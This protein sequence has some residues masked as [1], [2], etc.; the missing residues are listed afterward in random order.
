[1][2]SKQRKRRRK[3][4]AAQKAPQRPPISAQAE[5]EKAR[6]RGRRSAKGWRA[7]L[8][9]IGFL[10]ALWTALAVSL[11]PSVLRGVVESRLSEAVNAPV[12]IESLSV[13]PFT[14]GIAVRGIRVPYL[15]E[16]GTPDGALLTIERLDIRPRLRLFADAAPIQA[17]LSVHNPVLDITYLGN[18]LFSFSKLLP[19]PDGADAGPDAPLFAVSDLDLEG[20][21]ILLRDGPV[22]MLHTVSDVSFHVPLL[23]SADLP[24][25]PTLSALVNGTRINVEGR[26]EPDAGTLRTTFAIHTA[27]LHMEHFKRYL[28]DFTPLTLNSGTVALDMRFT[29]SQP[30]LGKVESS[31]SGTVKIEDAE[32]A[33]PEGAI[34]G[35]LRKGQASLNDFTLSER[36]IRLDGMELDGLYLRVSRDK[37]GR[38]DWADWLG[39]TDAN[40]ENLSPETPFVV[41][42]ADLILRNSDFTW[43]DASLADTQQIE[44]TGVDGRIAE[45]ST[46]P[47]AR[48]AMRLSFGISTEGV[49]A[50][51][52][53]GTLNPPSLNASLWVDDLP[54]MVL[55]PLLGETPLNDILGRIAIKGGVRFG[56]DGKAP[57]APGSGTSLAVTDA[58]ASV[59]ALSFGRGS[60]LSAADRKAGKDAGSPAVR[61]RALTFNGLHFDTQARSASV[62]ALSVEAP[63]VRV[64]SSGGIGLAVPGTKKPAGKTA[65]AA[66]TRLPEGMF[67]AALPDAAKTFLSDWKLKADGFRIAGGKLEHVAA[68]KA[69]KL[70]SSLDLETGPLSGDLTNTISL[71]L[72]ARGA[73]SGSL[74]LKGTLRPVPLRFSAGMD[75]ADLPLEWFDTPLRASTNLSPSGRLS[76]NLDAAITEEKGKGLD[77]LASGSLTVRDLRLKDARTEKVYALLRRL[78][79]DTFRFSSASSSFEAKAV[80]L[81]LLRMDVA[82]NAD[83]T[84]DI[85]DCIPKQ[86]APKPSSFRFSVASLKLQD[87][88]LLFRDQAHGSVSA[89]QDINA[90]VNG[91]SS[92]GGLPDIVLTGQLGGA[93]ITLSGSCNPFSTPPAAKL[94]FTAKG[95]DLAR[96][97]AYTRAYLGHP[98]VQGRLDLESAFTTS[99]WT[100]SLDNHIRL[101]KPVLGPKDTRPGAPDYPVSLGFALL[102][103]L[104]GN[105]ALDLPISGRLDDAALQVGGL[106]GKALGGLFT[107]VV[108][109]PFALLGGII[110]LVTPDDPALQVIAFPPGDTRINPA[111]QERLKRI[112]KALEEHPRV[113]IELVGMYEPASDT[114]G[115][116]RLRVIRKVQARHH[117]ALPAKQRAANPAGTIKL[118]PGEYERF[119]LHVYKDSPAGRKAAGGEEPDIMEQKLQALENVTQADLEALAHSRAEEVRAFLLKHGPGLGKRVGIASKGGLPD[120]RRGT[121]QVEIQLR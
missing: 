92:S 49:L 96:Y 5:E 102:E 66:K 84:L 116:K 46:R 20:G 63:E 38:I 72:R 8:V 119:L 6:S 98:V 67:T 111:A 87:A 12:T 3:R 112:A 26:T 24:F 14:L 28:S 2:A 71:T 60:S 16:V 34:V 56:P 76:A 58:E 42:G 89:V 93:P 107:K 99:G 10:C 79:A 18:G 11:P 25:A 32:I 97:S 43:V 80:L 53:E 30:H 15:E 40:P 17:A 36:R 4:R 64:A 23:H 113:K 69:E 39:G 48:T 101:E 110:G 22:G 83:K 118:S 44:I 37:A 52:G 1:M 13:N 62:K 90:A 106:V 105:I 91:L 78:S 73:S 57:G 19:A 41:E 29:L 31:L 120:V 85:L 74:N 86:T 7:C 88:A 65:P 94:S 54:L 35:R 121:A 81:D 77:I 47:G 103:D 51:D 70:I 115:L 21:T 9:G 61:V 55:R 75:A 68:G 104:R 114:R 50:V 108:T 59:S 95:V 100:F 109:S 27:P 82:L 33:A 117:A 45:Y